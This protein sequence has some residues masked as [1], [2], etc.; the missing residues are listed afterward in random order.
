MAIPTSQRHDPD[1]LRGPDEPPAG[2]G[3]R[4]FSR[5]RLLAG[6]ALASFSL[7]ALHELVP[8]E[9][10]H[11][12]DGDALAAGG[13]RGHATATGGHEHAAFAGG[14]GVDHA[15]NGFDPSAMLRD[16]DWGKTRRL[17]GGRV[18]REWEIHARD[19]EIEV[20]PG[21]HYAAWTY[22]G[23]VPGPTLRC[24]EGE[25]LR[26]RFVNAST[27]PHTMHFHGVHSSFM[28][29]VPGIGEGTGGGEIAPGG[30]FDY[31]FDA[32]PFG[33][34]LY[35]CH[36]AP[37][38]AHIAK[39]LYGAFI[40]DPA[41]GRPEADEL[42]MVMNAFDTNFDFSNEVYAVNTVGFHYQHHPIAVHRDELV[43]IYL[44]NL[45]EYDPINSF[46]LHGNFFHHYPTG[47]S[48]EPAELTD[49]VVQGQA[50]RCILE[51]RFPKPGRYMFH[52]HKTEFAELGWTGFFEVG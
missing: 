23:R 40:I 51:L 12:G 29:G 45:V 18:L 32:E 2:T 14:A 11:G 3:K 8:H 10:L 50:Q 46:H 26:I 24:R 21:V 33:M 9:G 1:G 27:H 34:H 16:F 43:R 47:T 4:V 42:V 19:R 6:G 41:R 52:A 15:A 22:N 37:L 5:R 28:D 48:L 7:P 20:A 25:R 44:A 38:A 30:S 17:P 36:V 39:G 35:H 49:I 13:H 31:E